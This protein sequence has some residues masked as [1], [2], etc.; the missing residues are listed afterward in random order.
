MDSKII[1]A[2]ILTGIV[3]ALLLVIL[4]PMSFADIDYYEVSTLLL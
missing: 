3:A 1:A 2:L 4:V